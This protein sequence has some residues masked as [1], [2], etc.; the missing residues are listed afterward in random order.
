MSYMDPLQVGGLNF[1]TFC[2]HVFLSFSSMFV[3]LYVFARHV[4]LHYGNIGWYP[5]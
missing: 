5:F 3:C 2:A 1:L 4:Q